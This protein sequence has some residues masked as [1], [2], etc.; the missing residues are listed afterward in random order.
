MPFKIGL[1]WWLKIIASYSEE[2]MLKAAVTGSLGEKKKRAVTEVL[3]AIK[4]KKK[5]ERKKKG[6]IVKN[7]LW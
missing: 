6:Y 1:P 7:G 4:F 5:K 3:L 2:K